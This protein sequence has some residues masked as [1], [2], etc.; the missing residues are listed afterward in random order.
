MLWQKT[1]TD[2]W[3][4]RSRFLLAMLSVMVGIFCVGSLFGMV[5]LLLS[6][7]DAAHKHSRPSH[8]NL[9]L[10]HDA[11]L[12]LLPELAKQFAPTRLDTLT[13]ISIRYKLKAEDP[14]WLSALLVFRPPTALQQL[15]I[16]TLSAGVW[17]HDDMLAIEQLS[18]TASQLSLGDHVIVQTATATLNLPI[19]GLIRQPFVKPPNLGGPIQF[20]AAPEFAR[21][22]AV[23]AHSFRQLLLQLPEPYNAEITRQQAS[24]LRQFF[25]D[26]QL[27]VN[28]TI[29]QDPEHHWGRPLLA[30]INGVLE[31]M[32]LAALGLASVQILI[33]LSAHITQ[34]SSQIGVMKALGASGFI[35]LKSYLLEALLLGV[36]ALIFA[37]PLAVMAAYLSSCKLLG[38]FNIACLDFVFSPRAL[39]LMVL[40]GLGMTLLGALQPIIA[41]ASL[42][43]RL[44]M[45]GYGVY[46]DFGRSCVD[47]YLERAA[48][49]CLSTLNAAALGNLFRRKGQL[50]FTQ[51]MLIIAG[52]VFMVLMSL[53][54]SLQL[55]LDKE[56]ARNH[57][58]VRLGL[59]Q[60]SADADVMR[61]ALSLPNSM[62]IELWQRFPGEL[63]HNT[64]AIKQHGSL[65]IQLYGI[66]EDNALY[67]PQL[68]AG[69]WL[70]PSDHDK[71]VVVISAAT[72]KLNGLS[73]GESLTIQSGK[74]SQDF[75]IIGIYRWITSSQFTIEPVYVPLATARDLTHSKALT[76]VAL[77][78]ALV[79][80]PEQELTYL[81]ALK[82]RIT[83]AHIA[84]DNFSTTSKLAERKYA[85]QQFKPV[86]STLLGLAVMICVVSGIGLSGTLSINVLQRT[87]E[88]GILSALGASEHTIFRLF[89][90][91]GC[92][93]GFIAWMLSVPLAYGIAKPIAV[94]LGETMLGMQLDF[95]FDSYAV[96]YWLGLVSIITLTASYFP[97]RKATQCT[98]QDC[99]IN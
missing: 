39:L 68:N 6:Q 47:R 90:M 35:L 82:Q 21:H 38:L 59:S 84:V 50:L 64:Q 27:P 51:S 92:W 15:D 34:Q 17:P 40:G 30:G 61:A 56:S 63:S 80:T 28:A 29:L 70:I 95:S 91:E 62:L 57:F 69:R 75:E 67:Q 1:R 33:T 52:I 25:A 19:N 9:M 58:T 24:H 87:K 4:Y 86:L 74:N 14:E 78:G 11:D 76:S 94:Q 81:N 48:A 18:A 49:Y 22:F 36:T 42:S 10:R 31:I 23:P 85:Q 55:T 16:S 7:M 41:G 99:L 5:D 26:H 13:T 79:S 3:R 66:P 53:I 89:L 54:A 71:K 73:I 97:A 12:A 45:T 8:I 88:I 37:L 32:A 93:H 98:V 2:F 96:V 60:D 20:F 77:L 43:P 72:A 44:A 83:A 65:G 46:S